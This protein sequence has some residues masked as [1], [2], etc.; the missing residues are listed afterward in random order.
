[1]TPTLSPGLEPL[2]RRLALRDT[3]S[4]EERSALTEVLSEV[5][6]LPAGADIVR[7]GERPGRSTLVLSGL[8]CRYRNLENGK[9]QITAIHLPGDFV[10]LHSFLL[11][12]MDHSVGALTDCQIITFPHENLVRVT[13][14]TPI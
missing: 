12:E 3:V 14:A 5:R 13:D 2:F 7:E 11:K 4:D 8:T 1:M 9:R 6:S 10:D